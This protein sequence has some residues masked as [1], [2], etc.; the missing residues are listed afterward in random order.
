MAKS[1]TIRLAESWRP[2]PDDPY[3]AD[4]RRLVRYLLDNHISSTNPR[5]ID[6]IRREVNFTRS[7]G[8]EAFQHQLL[9]PLRRDPKVFVGTSRS[10]IF[11]VT[12]PE[13]VDV[14]LGFYT[15]RVR[16]ELAH[17]RN[18]RSLARRTRLMAGY[19]A[20]IPENKRSSDDLSRRVRFT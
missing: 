13:D 2:E 10:G 15:W 4:K 14:T 3:G 20:C 7:Y 8:R 11:Q 18:F 16:S 17:A 6:S 9:G 12:T 5:P 19:Q 1:R